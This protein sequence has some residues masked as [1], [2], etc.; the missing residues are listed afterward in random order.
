[1]LPE[2]PL[3]NYARWGSQRAAQTA[4]TPHGA[5]HASPVA[6]SSVVA[7][8]KVAVITVPD[9]NATRGP[10]LLPPFRSASGGRSTAQVLAK[11]YYAKEPI[12]GVVGPELRTSLHATGPAAFGAPIRSLRTTG[13]R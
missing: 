8:G 13:A 3:N 6:S 11:L 5:R 10:V 12:H 4:G 2:I 1:M 7:S 9:D